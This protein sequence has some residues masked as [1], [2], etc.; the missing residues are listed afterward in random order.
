ME[1]KI[2]KFT[3]DKKNKNSYLISRKIFKNV[4]DLSNT[5]T[6]NLILNSFSNI[7]DMPKGVLRVKY[8][9]LLYNTFDYDRSKF[10]D[11]ILILS[12]F[13]EI[14]KSIA[15]F[16]ILFFAR[17]NDNIS[18]YDFIINGIDDQ[19]SYDR[20]DKLIRK[21][22][23][24]LVISNQEISVKNKK[25]NLFK[26][27]KI[28]KINQEAIKG[29][30]LK[31]FLLFLKTFFKSIVNNFNYIYFYN[32]ILF[33]II[34]NYSIFYN[35]RGKYF[36][37]DRFYNTCSIRNYFFKKFGGKLTST[38]QKN[39]VETCIS[40]FID[41]DIFFSLADEKFSIKRLREFGSRIDKSIPVGSF[42]LEHD[43]YRKK[44]DLSKVPKN[45]I[46]IMGLNPDGWLKM[47]NLNF[48]NYEHECRKWIKDISKM[49]PKAK[50][51]IKH[52]SNLKDNTFEKKFFEG[53]NVISLIDD[54]SENRSYG[55]IY[56]SNIIFSFGST[57]T[58]EAISM[59]K[60]GYF[61]DPGFGSKNFFYKL[62]NL[63]KIRINSFDNFKKIVE[64]KLS[65]SLAKKNNKKDKYCL[66]S[67]KVSHRVYKYFAKAG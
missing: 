52:H 67:D 1:N 4:I 49:Y 27:S 10:N 62:N 20:Y 59:D 39:I 53:S 18:Y 60:Q 45:E 21:F 61:M 35:N 5:E 15:I 55:Y 44:K 66:K 3:S 57:T 47:N 34:R 8:N 58:L 22:S 48:E 24:S 28:Q 16:F 12:I 6:S 65:K 54:K 46:L 50:I 30:R 14:L 36:M 19:R 25:V 23:S 32:L 2:K 56:R 9:K 38:P 29:K 42:F 11:K 37:E 64:K 26:N 40:F 51:M 7:F 17:K 31:V 41:T 63:K 33:S 43:W 13:S